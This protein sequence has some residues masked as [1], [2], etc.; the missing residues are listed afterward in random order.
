[1]S[2]RYTSIDYLKGICIIIVVFS[3]TVHFNLACPSA[4][5]WMQIVFLRGFFFATGWIYAQNQNRTNIKEKTIKFLCQFFILSLIAIT[6]QQVLSFFIQVEGSYINDQGWSLLKKNLLEMITFNGTGTIW[7]LPVLFIVSVVVILIN[8]IP[9][10]KIL[11][12]SSFVIMAT[13]FVAYEY[14]SHVKMNN[15]IVMKEMQMFNR[16][17][18]GITIAMFGLLIGK[19]CKRIKGNALIWLIIAVISVALGKL[20][21]YTKVF[22]GQ[23]FLYTLSLFAIAYAVG[24]IV[25]LN[26]VLRPLSWIGEKTLYI[27]VIHYYIWVPIGAYIFSLIN[28]SLDNVWNRIILWLGVLVMSIIT[29]VLIRKFEIVK[30]IFGEGQNKYINKLMKREK[31]E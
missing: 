30:T 11:I 27:M 29:T 4:M 8:R 9:N 10:E 13:C 15:Q 21:S 5:E 16:V 1:M 12:I 6:I 19:I 31:Y 2:K 23:Y 25:Q 3:H 28:V 24:K 20:C 26:K 7:F 18:M 22:N 17:L 14:L